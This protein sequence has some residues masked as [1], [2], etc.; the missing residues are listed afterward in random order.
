MILVIDYGMGN[1]G[2]IANM[3]KKAGGEALVSGDPK[4]LERAG[5]IILPGVGAFDHGVRNLKERGLWDPLTKRAMEDKV[6]VLGVC[7]GMQL[8]TRSSEEGTLPGLGWLRAKTIRF[9]GSIGLKIPHMGWNNVALRKSSPL[10]E[11]MYEEPMFYFVHS[12]HVA[13]EEPS[14]VLAVTEY[15]YE[16]PSC[17]QRENLYATQFHP[18]KSHKYGLRLIKNFIERV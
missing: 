1:I 10:F 17:L 6:P 5:K 3:I 8:F 4:D 15:G 2:S 18:E 13:C 12:Y 7:L 9:P 14:D 16:F 11:E